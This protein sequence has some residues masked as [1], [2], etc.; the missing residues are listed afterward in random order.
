VNQLQPRVAF[1]FSTKDRVHFTLRSLRSVDVDDRFDLIWIDG[2]D[3][4]EGQMLPHTYPFQRCRVAEVHFLKGGPDRAIR[5]GLERLL[6]LGYDFCGLIEND[7]ELDGGWFDRLMKLFSD[8]KDDG[9]DA[10][11]A[12]VRNVKSRVLFFRPTYTVNWVVG[13]GMVLFTRQAAKIILATYGS[14]GSKSVAHY[15]RKKFS[16]DLKDRW[17][18]WMDRDNRSLGCDWTY[19]M[20]LCAHG[21]LSVGS[22]PS[23]AKNLDM[24][25]EKDLRTIFV[26]RCEPATELRLPRIRLGS[27]I[28]LLL[29]DDA[30]PVQLFPLLNDF[31]AARMK[32]FVVGRKCGRLLYRLLWPFVSSPLKP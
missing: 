13:A 23:M 17:E 18:L 22:I 25:M 31:R 7:V 9:F 28:R 8:A 1:V 2:S 24:D 12:T 19:A 16:V 26:T 11:A 21:L 3:T 27:R 10:G 4:P 32:L 5:F 20:R 14:V 29:C 6:A 30:L 15:F